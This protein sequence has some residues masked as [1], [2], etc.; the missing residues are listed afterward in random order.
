MTDGTRD[1]DALRRR[2]WIA[3]GPG[4]V[5]AL[6]LAL[7]AAGRH[8]KTAPGPPVIEHRVIGD[9]ISQP[10]TLA[11]RVDYLLARADDLRLE[12]RQ[13]A[14]LKE[15]QAEWDAKSASLALELDRAGAEF[16][17]FME[18]TGDKASM[19]EIQAHTGP[20]AEL[21]RQ[22]SSLR[23]VYWQRALR[24]LDHKQRE[25]VGRELLTESPTKRGRP[26][27]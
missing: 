17:R 19:R 9:E 16:E 2:R 5:I 6:I 14:S 11:P 1:R 7:Q 18:S 22:V 20:V 3:L 12:A 13:L 10:E 25:V 26:H 24:V 23:R 8:H 27:K 15:L 4:I 21:S